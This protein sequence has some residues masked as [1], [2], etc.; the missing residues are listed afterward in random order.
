MGLTLDSFSFLVQFLAPYHAY[1]SK[2][3]L[4]QNADVQVPFFHEHDLYVVHLFFITQYYI[5]MPKRHDFIL[6]CIGHGQIFLTFKHDVLT[7]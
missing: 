3:T 7:L 5:V 1:N 2:N 4:L 6:R